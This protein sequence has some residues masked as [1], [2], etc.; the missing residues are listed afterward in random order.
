[1]K[2]ILILVMS[3]HDEFFKNQ[4]EKIKNTW[5]KP[6]FDGVYPNIDFLSYDG[7]T[8]KHSLDKENKVLHVRCEDDLSNTYKKTYYALSL[9]KSNMDYDYVFRTNTSTY[10]N[11]DMLNKFVQA[12]E[13][14]EVLWT[15][16]LYSLV[17]ANTP[18]PLNIY[19]RGNGLLFSKR[20]I[21]IL[22]KEGIN[23]LYNEI[24]DDVAIGNVLN[25]YWIKQNKNYLDHIKSFY[26]GWFRAITGPT[27]NNHSLCNYNCNTEDTNFWK[28]F[29]TIQTKMYRQRENE[30][31]NHDMLFN[32][33]KEV[34]ADDSDV[35]KNLE[36]SKNSNVFIGSGLG[37]ISLDVWINADKNKL[38][39]L[40]CRNKTVDDINKD[41]YNSNKVW[42]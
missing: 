32:I 15:S 27:Q 12:L 7:V 2:K 20:I 40:E 11:I 30:D 24:V 14:D 26:H 41:K 37:Y 6:I 17:E 42:Y 21:D 38:W 18:Y 19:G 4:V 10:V 13:D 16:E 5:A 31:E 39:N 22:L 9:I 34:V 3:C 8:D 28:T 29:I 23:I 33:M 25:S 1:M 35:Q 36:Y